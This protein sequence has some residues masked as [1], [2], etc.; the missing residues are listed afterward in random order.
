M[1]ESR[2]QGFDDPAEPSALGPRLAALR[3]E[4]A[5]RNLSGC[6]V[7]RSDQQQ[8][9]YVP[10]ADERLAWLTGFTGSAGLAVV[11]ADRAVL[12]VDGRYTLQ[13]AQQVDA[14]SWTIASLVEPPPDSWLAANLAKGAKI[15]FDPW[16]HTS[17][18][19]EKLA[20][21]C[22]QA[23]AELVAVES[24][25]IDSVWQ[26]RPPA[27]LGAVSVH[28]ERFAGESAARK[29]DRIRD[30]AVTQNLAAL[31]LSDAHA[32]AWAFN[33]RGADVAHTPLPLSYAVVPKD[34]RATIFIDSRKLSNTARNYLSE[35]AD[36]AEPDRLVPHLARLAA[37]GAAI[38]LDTATA[39]D[40]LSRAVVAA[41]GKPMRGPDPVALLKASSWAPLVPSTN[42]AVAMAICPF[43]TR[44]KRSR[45]SAPGV[46]VAMVRVT[47]VVP[48]SYWPPESTSSRSPGVTRRLLA[49]VTR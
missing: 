1:F 30:A 29:L 3:V 6:L 7:P 43:S 28:D 17:A 40:A 44:V 8:N 13:A 5:R 27:P 41:G 32:V 47:S 39:A 24:N 22:A 33:I 48:S 31:V 34:G 16:L 38:G 15:G 49:R 9:E 36:V 42:T 45:I 37:N 4:L 18:T 25:P 11:L 46:P 20:S 35:L 10:P 26:G 2:F 12:F 23:G 21:A 14:A 19:A